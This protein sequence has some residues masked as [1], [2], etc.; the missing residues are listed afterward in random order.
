MRQFL[1]F[2]A[3]LGVAFVLGC[4]DQGP[5]ATEG[6]P[7]FVRLSV[8]PCPTV[9]DCSGITVSLSGNHGVVERTDDGSNTRF[10]FNAPRDIFPS[11]G[12]PRVNGFTWFGIDPN[13]NRHAITVIVNC[14]PGE[15]PP[16]NG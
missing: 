11:G 5:V 16:C 13:N 10:F 4:Q 14:A 15:V 8:D 6:Q 1:P 2:A 9:L 12:I 3:L 7:V